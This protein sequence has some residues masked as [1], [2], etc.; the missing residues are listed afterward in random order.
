MAA[1]CDIGSALD[2]LRPPLVVGVRVRLLNMSMAR[3]LVCDPPRNNTWLAPEFSSGAQFLAFVTNTD[4]T[5]GDG[6]HWRV[7]VLER[8]TRIGPNHW[9]LLIADP[10]GGRPGGGFTNWRNSL[11]ANLL[12]MGQTLL[13]A[14]EFVSS[15]KQ[16]PGTDTLCGEVCVAIVA[17]LVEKHALS[18]H[19]CPIPLD[20]LTEATGWLAD[21]RARTDAR[22]S[23]V[24]V[25]VTGPGGDI[26]LTSDSD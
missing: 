1:A 13:P 14:E 7:C 5:Q 19:N 16:G 10:A 21:A 11:K 18:A 23:N 17:D 6:T 4:C 3:S 20:K 12:C 25:P 9:A 24:P 2:L 22:M 26:D 8:A 15:W